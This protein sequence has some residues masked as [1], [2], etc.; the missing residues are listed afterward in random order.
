MSC[1][2]NSDSTTCLY[3]KAL[4]APSSLF[5]TS[6][7]KW[8]K[9]DRRTWR[10]GFEFAVAQEFDT[11]KGWFA[12]NQQAGFVDGFLTAEAAMKYCD[13]GRMPQCF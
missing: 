7:K 10:R 8:T 3:C 11:G 4:P 6:T 13:E 2:H 1:P 12:V 5:P 9:V